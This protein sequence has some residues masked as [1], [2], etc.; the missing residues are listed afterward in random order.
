MST[1]AIA[2]ADG[3]PARSTIIRWRNQPEYR[4]LLEEEITRRE[5]DWRG[6]IAEF[7]G[8]LFRRVRADLH[9]KGTYMPGAYRLL[10]ARLTRQDELGDRASQARPVMLDEVAEDIDLLKTTLKA[11]RRVT[12]PDG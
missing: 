3:T 7:E 9:K 12:D 11:G 4:Q 1:Y 10:G 2:R 5:A 8:E 6:Q